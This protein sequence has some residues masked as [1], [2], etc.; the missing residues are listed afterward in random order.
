MNKGLSMIHR[1]YT[2]LTIAQMAMLFER[3][4]LDYF[5]CVDNGRLSSGNDSERAHYSRGTLLRGQKGE[6]IESELA[7]PRGQKKTA[8]RTQRFLNY[9]PF[10]AIKTGGGEG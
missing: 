6:S 2:N 10:K 7:C 9:G 3:R 8:E 4:K 1:C 5:E